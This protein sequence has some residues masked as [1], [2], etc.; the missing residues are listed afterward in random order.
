[1]L[2]DI[3]YSLIISKKNQNSN[4]IGNVQNIH[5]PHGE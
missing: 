5:M 4:K 2:D 3:I 1:M